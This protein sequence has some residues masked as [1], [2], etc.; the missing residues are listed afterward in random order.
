MLP[1]TLDDFLRDF[2]KRSE[3]LAKRNEEAHKKWAEEHPEQAACN[4][5]IT[6]DKDEAERILSNTP[7]DRS[8]DPELAFIMGSPAVPEIRR[9]W[10]RLCGQCPLGCGYNGIYYASAEHYAYGD[11]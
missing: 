4:H 11:W 1:P 3:E 8:M 7:P 9:R 2:D 5:G 10:P 6:F